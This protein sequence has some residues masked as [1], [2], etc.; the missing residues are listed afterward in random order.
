M[1]KK[2]ISTTS[3]NIIE[4]WIKHISELETVQPNTVK[5]YRSDLNDFLRFLIEYTGSDICKRNLQSVDLNTMRAWIVT[6][7]SQDKSIRSISRAIS[8]QKNFYKW[9]LDCEDIENSCVLNFSGPKVENRLPRPLSEKDAKTLLEVVAK[10]SKI[11]WISARDVALFT[12][13]YGCGLRVSEAL[14]LSCNVLP[15]PDILKIEG[16]GKKQR[17]IPILPI[18]RSSINTYCELCPYEMKPGSP[19][20]RGARGKQL[21]PKIIQNVMSRARNYMGLPATATPHALRHSFAT[22]LLSAGGDLRTI[23]ELLGHSSLS[24]TQ[25]YTG[26]DKDRLMEVFR[27][28]HPSEI[29]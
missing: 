23:Q 25:I 10:A 29:G 19:L 12:L 21:N 18:A 11:P 8:A 1:K 16:K 17:L 7:K 20:F 28:T 5:A 24:S 6:M 14:G 13:L 4:R 15:I 26:V 9:L 3:S 2:E 27:K 22:H